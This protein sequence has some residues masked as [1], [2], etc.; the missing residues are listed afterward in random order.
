MDTKKYLYHMLKTKQIDIEPFA[1]CFG[2]VDMVV[3][4]ALLSP[5]NFKISVLED[6]WTGEPLLTVSEELY[7]LIC[8]GTLKLRRK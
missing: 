5:S 2:Y 3:N 7:K 6:D 4:S 8:S 1:W